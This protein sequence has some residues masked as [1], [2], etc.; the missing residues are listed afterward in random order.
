MRRSSLMTFTVAA[1]DQNTAQEIVCIIEGAF[2]MLKNALLEQRILCYESC[3]ERVGASFY[4]VLNLDATNK[5]SRSHSKFT[6][7]NIDSSP[8]VLRGVDIFAVSLKGISASQRRCT[9]PIFSK[10][11]ESL[12]ICISIIEAAEQ[13]AV[14]ALR[15]GL[16][17]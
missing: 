1:L 4:H 12:P 15:L 7:G 9:A 14:N 2:A 3:W 17:R 5:Y 16:P 6:S 8:L 11:S 13:G 10:Y